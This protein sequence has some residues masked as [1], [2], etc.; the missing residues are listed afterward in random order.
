MNP[1]M[2]E[3]RILAQLERRLAQDDP[4]LAATLDALNQQFVDE[5]TAEP[6][7]VPEG[8]DVPEGREKQRDRWRVAVTAF[9]II[10]FLGLFLTAVLNSPSQDTGPPRGPG[11]GVSTQSERR[12]PARTPPRQRLPRRG[13]QLLPTDPPTACPRGTR[14]RT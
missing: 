9:T 12:F 13:P 7:A 2:D 11:A 1:E 6:A 14:A 3:A 5:P 10:A 4:A 8:A